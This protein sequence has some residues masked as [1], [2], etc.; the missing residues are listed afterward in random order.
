MPLKN[1]PEA[2]KEFAIQ[3]YKKPK[4]LENLVQ[5]HVAYTGTPQKHHYDPD[6]VILVLDAFSTNISYYEFKTK[7]ISY[8]EE[9]HNIVDM[10]GRVIQVMRIW[11]KKNS[12]G[13]RCTPF[14]VA[15]TSG[16]F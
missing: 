6:K 10:D 15:D 8:V 13:V 9:L 7:D 1:F 11:V 4:D 12:I 14:V 16:S 3:V 2:V 5:T